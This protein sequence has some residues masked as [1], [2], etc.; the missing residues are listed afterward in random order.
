[1]LIGGYPPRNPYTDLL[2][3]FNLLKLEDI[4]NRLAADE[5][6]GEVHDWP[7]ERPS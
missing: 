2:N 7:A 3:Y 5:F 1:V 6:F 4:L